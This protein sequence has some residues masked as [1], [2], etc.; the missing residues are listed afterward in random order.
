LLACRELIP[1][2]DVMAEYLLTELAELLELARARSQ[3]TASL[4]TE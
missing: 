4:S 2:L 3:S 1:D